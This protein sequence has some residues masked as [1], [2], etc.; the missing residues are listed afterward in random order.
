MTVSSQPVLQPGVDWAC[1]DPL[2]PGVCVAKSSRAATAYTQLQQTLLK[3]LH[4]TRGADA[5]MG[6]NAVMRITGSIDPATRKIVAELIPDSSA[7]PLS[8][9][10]ITP[11]L[12]AERIETLLAGGGFPLPVLATGFI[13]RHKWKLVGGLVG[14][15]AAAA[16]FL[17]KK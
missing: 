6:A 7:L 17:T 12:F 16:Y 9:L 11:W 5:V 3:F 2:Q 4:A 8:N 10:P 13:A 1:N 15:G 14:V